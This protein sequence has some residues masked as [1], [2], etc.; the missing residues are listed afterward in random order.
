MYKVCRF[1]YLF[2]MWDFTVFR[3][4]KNPKHNVALPISIT[5]GNFLS[6]LHSATNSNTCNYHVLWP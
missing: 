2:K 3:E 6:L 4:K 5:L 1:T